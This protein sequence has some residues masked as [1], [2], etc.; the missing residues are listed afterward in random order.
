MKS[1]NDIK[2]ISFI[3]LSCAITIAIVIL[4][5][6]I[7]ELTIFEILLLPLIS[8]IVA[9]K[10]NYKYSF[11]YF[12][13]SLLISF[14]DFQN[15]IFVII[16]SLLSGILFGKLIK[17]YIHGYYIIIVNALFLLIMQILGTYLVNL[18]YQIDL[19]KALSAILKLSETTFKTNYIL[20]LFAICISESSLSYLIIT[21][22]LK[23]LNY[24][25]N[26]KKNHFLP[27][28]FLN[29]FS[30]IT[31]SILMFFSHSLGYLFIGINTYLAILLAYYNFSFYQRKKIIYF[32]LPLY[33]F[34]LILIL[35]LISYVDKEYKPYLFLIPSLS[36]LFTSF[37]IIIYQKVIKKSKIYESLFDKIN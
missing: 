34:S 5:Y 13:S 24:E 27:V 1:K 37:Y 26:E 36:Q 4:N 18:I 7:G 14:I 16:P 19:I 28:L 29:I 35:I 9:S 32:Q 6:F 22:E 10:V 12:I 25:F 2:N 3:A 20:F 8:S 21:N 33:A 17:T 11:I 15:A 31:T 30:I 23:K